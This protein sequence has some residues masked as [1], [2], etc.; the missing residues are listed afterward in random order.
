MNETVNT[1]Q[2]KELLE[3]F[4]HEAVDIQQKLDQLLTELE[5]DATNT[6]CID[7]LFRIVHTLKG[8]AQG[9]D[10]KGIAEITH[11]LE[12]FFS[13]IKSGKF[14]LDKELFSCFFSASD[15][16]NQLIKNIDT[17]KKVSYKGIK[18]RLEVLLKKYQ[19]KI[20]KETPQQED[21]TPIDVPQVPVSEEQEEKDSLSFF[22]KVLDSMKFF[23]KEKQEATPSVD[24]K[25]E[26]R[27]KVQSDFLQENRPSMAL[28]DEQ[29]VYEALDL[30]YEPK[31]T[32]SNE[33]LDV[34]DQILVPVRKLDDLM[35]QVSQL[36]IER[37]RLV[38][39]QEKQQVR[40]TQFSSL[41]RITSDLQYSVMNVRLIQMGT[42]FSKFHRVVRDAAKIEGKNVSLKIVGSE[43]E[44]DRNILKTI[45]DSIL[46]LVRNAVGHG[47]ESSEE[48]KRKGK[49]EAG[50]ITLLAR[51]E[52]DKVVIE[53]SDDGKG[54]NVEGI[55]KKIIE[56][57]I[58]SEQYAK[59]L[60]KEE[61]IRYI[62]ESGFSNASSVN[63]ISGRGVGMDVVKK[64][65]ESIGGLVS[66]ETKENKGTTISLTLPASL[67]VKGV[68]LCQVNKQEY[69]FDLTYTESVISK[70]K[71]DLRKAGSGLITIH[72]EQ[73]ISVVFL[74]DLLN[75]KM[76]NHVPEGSLITTFDA[77]EDDSNL[78]MIIITH[79]GKQVGVVVDKLLQQKEIME[80]PVPKP[81]QDNK[82]LSGTTIL[83]NGK[84]CLVIDI[85]S[86]INILY[87]EKLET[88]LNQQ[89]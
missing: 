85:A 21:K 29:S 33:R 15:K 78:D 88:S 14:S 38:S 9:M 72:Q 5:S 40:N 82:L 16:L 27:K 74:K 41:M 51:N 19:E 64:A 71:S 57:K 61:V 53:V 77:L 84:V 83:G 44:I 60:S 25:V 65:T 87:K 12:E 20:S 43:I 1:Y 26:K 69:A 66:I 28:D 55:R 63:E 79:A 22:D 52:K 48:R 58:V 10:L 24:V 2:D 37:D 67:I 32:E 3:A 75:L 47:I 31:H 62:F 73:A 49:P 4:T 7:E 42:L 59:Q 86:I 18:T 89:L 80:K 35:N 76:V 30:G 23:K 34:S 81:I 70:K 50:E 46:H 45:S 68:L 11:I 56:N 6:Q 17:D 39:N 54:I 36:I 13:D 8:N